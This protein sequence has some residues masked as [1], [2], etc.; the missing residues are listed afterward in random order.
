M[1]TA[2]FLFFWHESS[3]YISSKD[4][5][6]SLQR[7]S[8]GHCSLNVTLNHYDIH[9]NKRLPWL[10]GPLFSSKHLEG[11]CP[12]LWSIQVQEYTY[13]K[14]SQWQCACVKRDTQ[15]LKH[16]TDNQQCRETSCDRKSLGAH[17]KDPYCSNFPGIIAQIFSVKGLNVEQRIQ[18]NITSQ[19]TFNVA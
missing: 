19:Y 4:H 12:K 6:Q 15:N 8:L 10:E 11:M 16:T 14:D 7:L 3:E 5:I 1:I 9:Q 13:N 18:I 2:Y 17:H